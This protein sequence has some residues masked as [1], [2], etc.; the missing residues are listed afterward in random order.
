MAEE[1]TPKA[2]RFPSIVVDEDDKKNTE[3]EEVILEGA[4]EGPAFTSTEVAVKGQFAEVRS[5]TVR[6]TKRK[7]L[8]STKKSIRKR[9][10]DAS[11]SLL[12]RKAWAPSVAIHLAVASIR[13]EPT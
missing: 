3:L 1:P 4:G 8:R 5:S 9:K 10:S 11:E 6:K 13:R 2:V 12:D 7:S